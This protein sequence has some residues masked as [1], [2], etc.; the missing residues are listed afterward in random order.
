M[1]VAG[2]SDDAGCRFQS[3]RWSG[4]ADGKPEP[5]P[6]EVDLSGLAPEAIFFTTNP[7]KMI[8]LSDDGAACPKP[9]GFRMRQ[10]ALPP[11]L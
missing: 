11:A 1:V 2:S 10:I 3:Y 9:K 4:K 8:V 5:M 7:N 6:K